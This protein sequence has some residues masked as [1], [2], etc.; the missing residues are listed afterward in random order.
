MFTLSGSK[1]RY[2]SLAHESFKRGMDYFA[3]GDYEQAK[4]MFEKTLTIDEY[5]KGR[6]GAVG[7]NKRADFRPDKEN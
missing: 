6:P 4:I 2:A 7:E 1:N 5:H 3:A